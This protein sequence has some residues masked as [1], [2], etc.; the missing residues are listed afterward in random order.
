MRANFSSTLDE[1][2]KQNF[3]LV[4]RRGKISHAIVNLDFLEDLLALNN[5]EYL[6]SIRQAREDYKK[7]NTF[8]HDQV[9]GKL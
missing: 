4:A 6:T 1:L 3:L 7:G 8:S 2:A 5:K 9:F